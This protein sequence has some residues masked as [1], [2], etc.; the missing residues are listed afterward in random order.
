VTNQFLKIIYEK[1]FHLSNKIE[2]FKP[3]YLVEKLDFEK[4]L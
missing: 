3:Q 4:E 2:D 1:L